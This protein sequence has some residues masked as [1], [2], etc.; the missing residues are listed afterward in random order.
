MTVTAVSSAHDSSARPNSSADLLVEEDS[1]RRSSSYVEDDESAG[2]PLRRSSRHAP[3]QQHTSSTMLVP[4]DSSSDEALDCRGSASTATDTTNGPEQ[5]N[6]M[7]R[8]TSLSCSSSNTAATVTSSES[9][10]AASSPVEAH[11]LTYV[12]LHQ[13]YAGELL[14]MLREF[15][16]LEQQL[17]GG[18]AAGTAKDEESPGSRERREKLHSFIEH[19]K[20]TMSQIEQ[21]LEAASPTVD[22]DKVASLEEHIQANLLPVKIRLKKQ[23]AAQQ[24]LQRNP[25]HMPANIRPGGHAAPAAVASKPTFAAPAPPP[26]PAVEESQLGRRLSEGFGSRLTKKIH[27]A[28][29]GSSATSVEESAPPE[30][31]VPT[32]A[33]A[34]KL[35]KAGMAG[36]SLQITSSVSAAASVHA[37]QIRDPVILQAQGAAVTAEVE[38]AV[39]EAPPPVATVT[40]QNDDTATTTAAALDGEQAALRRKRKRRRK[41]KRKQQQAGEKSRTKSKNGFGAR[42]ARAVEYICALCNETYQSTCAD[43]PWWTLQQQDCP[44]CEKLQV[45]LIVLCKEVLL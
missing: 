26:E 21:G 34:R 20:D 22:H 9:E 27:G 39:E 38:P 10:A 13:K 12:H 14:Y 2:V 42:K 7:E 23:L 37:M 8:S 5:V 16:K 35:Y 15:T 36:D 44:K 45:S 11:S 25:A 40:V 17:L 43:N 30:A 3:Q 1:L 32:P 29:L 31:T 4:G 33:P 18:A 24:G 41:E 19:L 28:V 6:S